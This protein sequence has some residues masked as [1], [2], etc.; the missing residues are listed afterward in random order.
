MFQ[1]ADLSIRGEIA[2][3]EAELLTNSVG[4]TMSPTHLSFTSRNYRQTNILSKDGK[5]RYKVST[6]G[7]PPNEFTTIYRQS[8]AGESATD[9]PPQN[10][11]LAT[12]E[13]K[14]PAI[15]DKIWFTH[16]NRPSQKLYKWLKRNTFTSYV[17]SCRTSVTVSLI[18][19]W[20][21]IYCARRKTIQMGVETRIRRLRGE[22]EPIDTLIRHCNS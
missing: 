10:T 7:Q 9:A 22:L 8:V 5:I 12:V 13:W 21:F 6:S 19:Q 16:S 2:I 1:I 11:A 14:F 3:T 4:Y 18:V 20:V 17:S 15:D